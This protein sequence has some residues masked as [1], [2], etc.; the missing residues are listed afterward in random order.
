MKTCDACA[1]NSATARPSRPSYADRRR[2]TTSPTTASR[3]QGQGQARISPR[4]RPG[5][6][7]GGGCLGSPASRPSHSCVFAIASPQKLAHARGGRAGSTSHPR[8][9]KKT[10]AGCS[11]RVSQR[12]SSMPGVP[13]G[14]SATTG[15]FAGVSRCD[16][17]RTTTLSGSASAST[18]S[19]SAGA[20]ST[21]SSSS[22]TRGKAG[23]PTCR[24]R[25]RSSLAAARAGVFTSRPRAASGSTSAPPT[26]SGCRWRSISTSVSQRRSACT[27]SPGTRTPS[28]G[29]SSI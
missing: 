3:R 16:C 8:A 27:C 4:P 1:S 17:R 9:G 5:G 24:C 10:A 14:S 6:M 26:P 12:R 11:S 13:P 19:T 25:T 20:G 21:L 23:G 18:A 22:S 29:S 15:R 2:G 28:S 7:R